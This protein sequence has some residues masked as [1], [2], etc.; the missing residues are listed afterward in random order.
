MKRKEEEFTQLVR[1]HKGTIY[2]VC[3]L[4]SKEPQ[5]VDDLFQEVL[6][7]LWRGFDHFEGRSEVRTWI[8]RVSLNTC[9]TAD[10]QRRRRRAVP[11]EGSLNLYS[12]DD[13]ESRQ[14]RQLHARI[15]HL[16]PF[17]RAIVLLWL[18]GISYQEI[19]SIVGIS[20]KHVSVRLYR[21]KEALKQMSNP[22]NDE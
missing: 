1:T 13:T 7:N 20:A 4:F 9:I 8:W 14:I 15:R 16:Q 12:D 2:S 18:E 6:I 17:D 5:E 3:Y 22:K 21:I 10:R 19:G 11:L